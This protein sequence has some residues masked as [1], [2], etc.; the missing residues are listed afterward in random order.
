MIEVHQL[1]KSFGARVAVDDIQFSIARGETFG[2]LGPNGAGKSTTLGMLVGLVRPDAGH[3]S[4]AGGVPTDL[5]TRMKIG[6]A[7]QALSLYD[8]L[9]ATDNLNFFGTIYG[10]TGTKLFER[11]Q[12]ALSFSGLA[13]R[14]SDR[15]NTYSGGMKRRLNIAVGLIHQPVVLLLDEPTVGVDP[16]SRNHIL[17]SIGNLAKAGMTI[18]YTT[19]Y[20]EEAEKLCDRVAIIDH[21]R[22]LASDSIPELLREYGGQYAVTAE[23]VY[24]PDRLDLPGQSESGKIQFR[25]SQPVEDLSGLQQQGVKFGHIAIDQP[26]LESVFLSLTGRTLRD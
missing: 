4:I 9:S 20:M 6:I 12:W 11:V 15:V 23:I 24:C 5:Q 22:I 13:D 3:L 19:H 2:L 16:Q 18:I 1:R 25:S 10:L 26:N 8:N 14:A 17:E 7:P 21:G